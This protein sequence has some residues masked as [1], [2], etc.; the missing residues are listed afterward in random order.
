MA[1]VLEMARIQAI[2]QLHAAKWSQRR[3]A[4]ELGI[5]RGTV[6]RCLRALQSEPKPAIPPTGSDGSKA[7]TFEGAPPPPADP[8]AGSEDADHS[9]VAKAAIP[10]TG[11]VG[12][13][14]PVLAPSNP[15]SHGAHAAGRRSDCEPFRELILAKLDQGLSA[16]RIYQ[17]LTSEHSTAVGYNSVKRFVRRLR[18]TTPLPFRRMEC[19]AGEEAQVDFGTGARLVGSDGKQRKSYVFRVVLSHSRKGYSEATRRQTTEDFF[20]CLENAFSQFGGVPKTLIIDN[21]KAAV[22]HPDWFD[23]VLTPKVQSFCQH[24]GT[25]ILPTKPRT[26]RHKGKIE[27]GVKYVKNNGLKGRTFTN[28]EEENRFLLDWEENVADRRIHGTTKRQVAKVFEESERPALLPLPRERF[29]CFQEAKRTVHRDG[30]I[31]VAKA[32]YSVPP[33]YLGHELWARWDARLVR[34]FNHRWEQVAI[35]VRTEPG[36][37]DTQDGHVAEEK[38]S[39]L[40]RGAGYLL[41]KV[42]AVGPR[43][44]QWAQAMVTAR[45]IQ[46]TRVLQGLL[47]LAKKHASETLEEACEIALSYGCFHLRTVRRLLDRQAAKQELLP[48]LEEHPIIRP[49]DDYAAVVRQAIHRQDGRSSMSEGFSRHDRTKASGGEAQKKS[50]ATPSPASQGVTDLLPSRSGYPSSG[51]SSAEP[52]SVSPDTPSVVPPSVSHQEKTDE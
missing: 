24:Y 40:E 35:H 32:Y 51:C 38:I 41:G 43:T 18:T 4:R 26:P 28:V 34:I 3:I 23:P 15:P 37:F 2:Q 46:G 30:H 6:A 48:F 5:D 39:G 25:V 10:P 12:S 42:S 7:A 17:D 22:A 29:P 9:G 31:E 11:E 20:R 1:H 19:A 36:R 14:E 47:S 50:L 44:Q 8:N 16:Q 21:L 27:A 13:I 33:E 49:L 45:G 52:D